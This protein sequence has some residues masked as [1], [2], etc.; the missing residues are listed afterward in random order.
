MLGGQFVEDLAMMLM[1]CHGSIIYPHGYRAC[2]IF[3]RMGTA[4][5]PSVPQSRPAIKPLVA[6]F[7]RMGA[8]F[9]LRGA[10]TNGYAERVDGGL[11]L[12]GDLVGDWAERRLAGYIDQQLRIHGLNPDNVG[13]VRVAADDDIAGQQ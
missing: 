10:L 2:R 7:D 5:A 12:A 3:G 1:F 6:C 13:A 9:A 8:R 11:Q 4:N